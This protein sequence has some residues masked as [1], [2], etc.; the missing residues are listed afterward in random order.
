MN[1]VCVVFAPLMPCIYR[2]AGGKSCATSWSGVFIV[3][4]NT[5]CIAILLFISSRQMFLI[6][7]YIEN[8]RMKSIAIKK[9]CKSVQNGKD[10]QEIN[11]KLW[12]LRRDQINFE[13]GPLFALIM[14]IA[15]VL[16]IIELVYAVFTSFVD[17]KGLMSVIITLYYIINAL[18]LLFAAMRLENVYQAA[19]LSFLTAKVEDFNSKQIAREKASA[20]RPNFLQRTFFIENDGDQLVED[21]DIKRTNI[22]DIIGNVENIAMINFWKEQKFTIQITAEVSITITKEKFMLLFI[23]LVFNIFANLDDY[24]YYSQ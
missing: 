18:M 21:S 8:F 23:L 16:G 11:E 1:W 14:A 15:V 2:A 24:I 12:E 19:I 7:S 4:W 10:L 5:L 22:K 6:Y 3:T 20:K 13:F 9:Q 17:G